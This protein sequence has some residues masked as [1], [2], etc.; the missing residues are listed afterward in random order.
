MRRGN[1]KASLS[2]SQDLFRGDTLDSRTDDSRN[3]NRKLTSRSRWGREGPPE[4]AYGRVTNPERFAPLHDAALEMIGRLEAD[5]NVQRVEGYG[6]DEELESKRG[7]ARPSV[8]LSPADPEAAPIT[9]VFTDFPGLFVRFGRWKEEL[10]PVCGCDACDETAESGI[11]SLIE[12]V[13][14][15]TAHGFRE[16]VQ[17]PRGPFGRGSLEVEW[18]TPY[19]GRH[20]SRIN[21]D[22]ARRMSG[23]RRRLELDWKPWPRRRE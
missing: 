13:D 8:R 15:V 3:G 6:L 23:G 19:L 12:K 11:E 1:K 18:G 22:L 10:F 5:F 9:V 20:W 2:S 14:W 16:A 17:A 4:E 21:R 7:L